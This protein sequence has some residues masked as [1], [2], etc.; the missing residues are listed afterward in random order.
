MSPQASERDLRGSFVGSVD[1]GELPDFTVREI[2]DTPDDTGIDYLVRGLGIRG[3]KQKAELRGKAVAWVVGTNLAE[4]INEIIRSDRALDPSSLSSQLSG[5]RVLHSLHIPAESSELM[6]LSS[7]VEEAVVPGNL[8][9]YLDTAADALA[10][11][12]LK[13]QIMTYVATK[14]EEDIARKTRVG[15]NISSG[16]ASIDDEILRQLLSQ[17]FAGADITFDNLRAILSSAAE[18][19]GARNQ[20][21]F[22]QVSDMIYNGMIE[23]DRRIFKEAARNLSLGDRARVSPWTLNRESSQKRADVVREIM[24]SRVDS[25]LL[26][27]DEREFSQELASLLVE[28]FF[29]KQIHHIDPEEHAQQVAYELNQDGH[30]LTAADFLLQ[31]RKSRLIV[32]QKRDI[33]QYY[34]EAG[35]SPQVSRDLARQHQRALVEYDQGWIY[36]QDPFDG[37]SPDSTG[38]LTFQGAQNL[39]HLGYR[40]LMYA[41]LISADFWDRIHDD[42]G[43][44]NVVS[45]DRNSRK[46]WE[47]AQESKGIYIEE[48]NRI[49]LALSNFR[50]LDVRVTSIDG[51]SSSDDEVNAKQN[52]ESFWRGA[53][54]KSGRQLRGTSVCGNDRLELRSPKADGIKIA[55]R[56]SDLAKMVQNPDQLIPLFQ[57]YPDTRMTFLFLGGVIALSSSSVGQTALKFAQESDPGARDHQYNSLRINLHRDNVGPVVNL[58]SSANKIVN[59]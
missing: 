38:F 28:I 34:R 27:R 53:E 24:V 30:A 25:Y 44:V 33:S 18:F 21:Q 3:N 29:A 52:F 23:T 49:S 50:G 5:L 32:P 2:I 41:A 7:I 10:S 46:R 45:V 26:D 9:S 43:R 14:N 48:N 36:H 40:I 54:A 58:V 55:F 13:S 16:I 37:F 47:T 57:S 1:L 6:R 8:R 31:A 19:V 17:R 39:G 59:R 11:T 35:F 20:N 15:L 4:S 56:G 12:I 22:H 42:R 51:L